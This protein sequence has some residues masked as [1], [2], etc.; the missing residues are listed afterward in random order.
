MEVAVPGGGGNRGELRVT[1]QQYWTFRGGIHPPQHKHESTT[2]PVQTALLPRRLILPLQQHIGEPAKPVV[3]L[4]EHV[5]RG[6][7]IARASDFVSAPIHA[8]SSGTV[9]DIGNHPIPHPSGLSAPSIVIETDGQD[10]WIERRPIT[11]YTELNASALRNTI[12]EAGIVGLGGAGFPTFIKLNPGPDRIIDTLILNG[13]E[14]EPYIT[15]D[16]MLLRERP[17]EIIAGSFI[18]RHALQA[19]HCVI[20]IEDNKPEAYEIIRPLAEAHGIEVAMV[21]TKYPQGSEKQLIQVITGKE[22]P[23]N[24]LPVHM[25][26]VV[27]NVATAVAVYRAIQHGEPLTSRY[28]TVVG[29]GVSRPGNLD[30]HLGTPMQD[31]ISQCGGTPESVQRLIMGGPM[32]GFALHSTEVPV[33][34]TT[35]CIIAADRDD[36]LQTHQP[37]MPCIRCGA[38]VDVCPVNLLPQQ[39]YWYSRAKDM[40]KIQE[41]NLFDCIECG[42]C[43]YVCPSN[44]PLVQYY[45]FAKS[46]IWDREREREKSNHARDRFEFRKQRLEREK[47]EKAARHQQK[48]AQLK[49]GTQDESG[50][51]KNAGQE[52]TIDATDRIRDKNATTDDAR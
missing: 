34:K 17:E 49:R 16:D 11:N 42:C 37:V 40:D 48:K 26:V 25:G 23:S 30:V 50:T 5:L 41:Y 1:E 29:S 13:V 21:P 39:L 45:R 52:T 8:S 35:N 31:L 20:A 28:V 4:G 47:T 46:E 33:I 32:M 7:L 14:C 36:M 2:R 38:C 3:E 15:C 51:D 22:V 10:R 12:R 43:A 9:V 6:Q 27:H 24:G 18:M 19:R 44:I